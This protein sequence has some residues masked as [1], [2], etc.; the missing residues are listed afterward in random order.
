MRFG[1]NI[2]QNQLRKM[3]PEEVDLQ[4]NEAAAI[5]IDELDLTG[6]APYLDV[7]FPIRSV[8]ASARS[9]RRVL[10]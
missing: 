4:L 5:R 2:S 1:V 3:S 8:A 7:D 9:G 6:V 10:F